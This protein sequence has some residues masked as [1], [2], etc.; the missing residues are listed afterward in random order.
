MEILLAISLLLN[1]Y[2]F[3]KII[4][5][6]KIIKSHADALTHHVKRTDEDEVDAL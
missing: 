5:Q 2:L 6:K 3:I 4:K 1:I